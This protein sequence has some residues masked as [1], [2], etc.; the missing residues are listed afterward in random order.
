M[1][2]LP[3]FFLYACGMAEGF[4]N[5]GICIISEGGIRQR[6]DVLTIFIFAGYTVLLPEEHRFLF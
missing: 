6:L 2:N 3:C 4:K 1:S 5:V